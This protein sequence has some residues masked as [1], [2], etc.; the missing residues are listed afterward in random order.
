M[1]AIPP[2]DVFSPDVVAVPARGVER[3][4]T[5]EISR[6]LGAGSGDGIAA[7]IM[8]PSPA[9]L[10]ADVLAA[11]LGVAPEDDPWAGADRRY[12]HC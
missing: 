7:N 5:Q 8:F 6:S 12:G 4:L 3:W 1:L 11:T 10:V 9:Q 2:A